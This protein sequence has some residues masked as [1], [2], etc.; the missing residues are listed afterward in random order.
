MVAVLAD[1]IPMRRPPR[2]PIP[3]PQ[4]KPVPAAAAAYEQSLTDAY[5][6][7]A[8]PL[9]SYV[10]R[11]L[12]TSG[13]PG[14]RWTAAEDIVQEVF[15]A[16]LRRLRREQTIDLLKP[17]LYAAAKWLCINRAA[18]LASHAYPLSLDAPLVTSDGDLI[19]ADTLAGPDVVL[20]DSTRTRR[21]ERA[22]SQLR[23]CDA[24]ALICR[25]VLG[26]RY[27]AVAHALGA[28]VTV[29]EAMDRAERGR[30]HFA[31]H[32]AMG[33]LQAD[34]DRRGRLRLRVDLTRMKGV[35]ACDD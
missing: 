4:P 6:L 31:A 11:R 27:R 23:P 10:S 17:W 26:W 21:V 20:P 30:R 13:V 33:G 5:A 19:L 1:P 9:R 7:Y 25:E 24:Q 18:R 34:R 16:T 8:Q 29:M 35:R 15:I 2:K 28:Q 12:L 3:F 22:L 32:Y 14:D